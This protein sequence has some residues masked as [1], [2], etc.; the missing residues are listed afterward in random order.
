MTQEIERKYLVDL[1]R[2][3]PTDEGVKIMQCYLVRSPQMTLRLRLAG[4]KAFLTLNGP[5]CGISRSEFEYAIPRSDALSMLK[6][7]PVSGSIIKTRYYTQV[8]SHRW[9][10]DLFEGDNAGLAVAEIELASADETFELP[11]WVTCEVSSDPRYRNAQ[12]VEHP[13]SHWNK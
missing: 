9:E 4:E 6:E 1:N 12:L 10:I 7:F 13:Y 8:G 5:T 2:W 11:D 3:Q